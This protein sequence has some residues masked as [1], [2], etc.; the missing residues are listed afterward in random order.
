MGILELLTVLFVALKLLDIIDWS[1]WLVFAPMY[2]YALAFLVW[3]FLFVVA[4]L[5]TASE[6]LG[7]S[8]KSKKRK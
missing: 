3:L 7:I 8:K 6:A 2:V 5:I 4:A 1:W